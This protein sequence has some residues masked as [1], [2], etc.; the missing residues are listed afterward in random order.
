MAR[1]IDAEIFKQK[2]K[3]RLRHEDDYEARATMGIIIDDLDNQPSAD[4]VE[5]VRCKGCKYGEIDDADF[6][7]QYLCHH[8]GSDWNDGNHFCAYGKRRDI[9]DKISQDE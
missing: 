4:V 9:H 5:V 3:K 7:N 6:P 8:H 2:L 1:Y